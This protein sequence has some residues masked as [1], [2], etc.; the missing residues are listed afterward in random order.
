[1]KS[2]KNFFKEKKKDVIHMYQFIYKYKK[3]VSRTIYGRKDSSGDTR[4][5]GVGGTRDDVFWSRAF[6]R[7]SQR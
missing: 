2:D 6:W 5:N 3:L 1:M 4:R 7:Q